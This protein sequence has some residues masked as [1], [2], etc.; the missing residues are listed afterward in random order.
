M[1]PVKSSKISQSLYKALH[2][3]VVNAFI[4]NSKIEQDMSKCYN[5]SGNAM[6][7]KPSFWD[8]L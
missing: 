2:S 5:I 8:K 1:N 3:C 6:K 7:S 4:G